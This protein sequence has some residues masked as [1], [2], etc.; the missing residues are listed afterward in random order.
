MLHM[1]HVTKIPVLPLLPLSLPPPLVELRNA[2]HQ[3]IQQEL[4]TKRSLLFSPT[5]KS[6][7]SPAHSFCLSP[8]PVLTRRPAQSELG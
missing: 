1:H 8:A 5:H 4:Q 3:E 2:L 7:A 6:E